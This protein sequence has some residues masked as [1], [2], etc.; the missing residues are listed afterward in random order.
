MW[1]SRVLP[2]LVFFIGCRDDATCARG[3]PFVP[4]AFNIWPP[5]RNGVVCF[6]WKRGG[7]LLTEA[8][9][10]AEVEKWEDRYFG[11][12]KQLLERMGDDIG[13]IREDLKGKASKDDLIEIKDDLREVKAKLDGTATKD[14]L[15]EVNVKIDKLDLKLQA[16]LLVG[17]LGV[18]AATV[19]IHTLRF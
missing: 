10:V 17:F 4:E 13:D 14:E 3:R 8:M 12:Q 15:K 16:W 2:T 19:V 9:E 5:P 11:V 7:I 18:I 1:R 6:F